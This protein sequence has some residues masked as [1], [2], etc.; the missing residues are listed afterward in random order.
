MFFQPNYNAP[1]PGVEKDTPRKKGPARLIELVARDIGPY[2]KAGML[3][4]VGFVPGFAIAG[5][6]LLLRNFPL[7]LAGGLAGGAIAGPGLAGLYDTV[8]RTLRDE[9][10]Y[11]WHTY[12]R[13]MKANWKQAMIAGVVLNLLVGAQVFAGWAMLLG[14]MQESLAFLA[15]VG[16]NVMVT[17]MVA[18]CLFPQMVVMDVPMVTLFKNALFCAV[19]FAPRVL[20]ASLLQIAWW[21]LFLL[22][23][24]V[25]AILVPFMGF[26]P[27]VLIATLMIYKP[28]EKALDLEARLAAR[29]EQQ[30]GEE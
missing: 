29:R 3:A 23:M 16:L 27:I 8:A 9:P 18:T 19:G 13:A 7:V 25:S 15:G 10:G 26:W 14:A 28:L 6:G 4:L 30:A 22:F 2:W 21:V 11:W 24:P 5:A 12:K 20:A 1:G 17:A